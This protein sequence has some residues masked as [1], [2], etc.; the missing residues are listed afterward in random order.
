MQ[1]HDG[2]AEREGRMSGEHETV[3]ESASLAAPASSSG[4]RGA[5]RSGQVIVA[6]EPVIARP[7]GIAVARAADV[8]LLCIEMGRT[9]IAS[10][11]R[12]M[13]LVGRER[14]VGCVM[15]T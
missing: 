5:S 6:I 3:L 11:R 10:A 12:T 13:E 8:A 2:P 1:A 9:R 7:L 4:A 14:F 15:L